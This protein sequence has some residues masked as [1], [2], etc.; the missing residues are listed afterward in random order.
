MNAGICD[1][2]CSLD[3]LERVTRRYICGDCRCIVQRLR[4]MMA[5]TLG[6]VFCKALSIPMTITMYVESTTYENPNLKARI[7]IETFYEAPI[8]VVV[9]IIVPLWVP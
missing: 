3:W 7:I 6:R 9:K 2:V 8:W 4:T 1:D 5:E